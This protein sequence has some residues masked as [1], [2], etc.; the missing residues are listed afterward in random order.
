MQ[1]ATPRLVLRE[2]CESDY[3]ALRELDSD[4]EVLRYEHALY[5]EE[6]TRARLK[7]FLADRD[8]QP[9][10]HYRLA[11]T[12]RPAD[13]LRGWIVLTSTISAIREY[14]I[15]W[16][17]HHQDWG[18]G[19][20]PEAAREV[21]RFAFGS[22]QAHRV[23]AFCHAENR[24]SLRVMEKLGMQPEGRLREVRWLNQAWCD[25]WVYAIL[26]REFAGQPFIAPN[27]DL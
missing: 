4:P 10:T 21:L 17:L 23:V 11:I 22:L 8:Q 15:G 18:R 26:E 2:I 5:S 12:I 20:A 13:R 25:E 24:A 3:P 1:L 9:V 27:A 14:E 7:S 19:Y 6:E 16:T